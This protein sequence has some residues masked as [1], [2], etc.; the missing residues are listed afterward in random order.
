M[1]KV[2]HIGGGGQEALL[3]WGAI[4]NHTHRDTYTH[5]AK[6]GGAKYNMQLTEKVGVGVATFAPPSPLPTSTITQD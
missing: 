3:K 1:R 6:N 4:L 2:Y 5:E